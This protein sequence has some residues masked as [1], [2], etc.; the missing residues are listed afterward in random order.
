MNFETYLRQNYSLACDIQRGITKDTEMKS[1]LRDDATDA[2]LVM[3]WMRDYGL[4]QGISTD[5]RRRVAQEF[6][7]FAQR[8]VRRSNITQEDVI[9]SVYSELLTVLFLTV[10][11]GWMS[12]TS[13]LL[14]CMYPD[15]VVIYD[16]FVERALVVMQRLDERLA[17]FPRIGIAPRVQK[18]GDVVLATSHYMNYQSMVRSIYSQNL[19]V[20]NEL[21]DNYH[22]KYPHDIRIID[23]L[24]WMIGNPKGGGG[25]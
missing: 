15:D 1:M 24:L 5:D 8:H 21:R 11:R 16:S 13:K 10:N 25:A 3:S 19:S 7:S 6:L 22:E 20:L 23:K 12:A 2:E 4:Y 14:W 17:G 18:E 9:R